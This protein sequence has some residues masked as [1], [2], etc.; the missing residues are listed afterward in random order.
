MQVLDVVQLKIK[1]RHQNEFV[2]IE[3]LCV[4]VICMSFKMQEISSTQEDSERLSKLE[5]GD[6]DDNSSELQ[7]GLLIGVDYHFCFFTNKVIKKIIW[8]SCLQNYIRLGA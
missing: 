2:F 6:F 4:P 3:A 1:H 5:L 8:T 7:V